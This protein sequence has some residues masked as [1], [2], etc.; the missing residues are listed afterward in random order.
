MRRFVKIQERFYPDAKKLRAVFDR[1]FRDPKETRSDRFVWDYWHVPDQYTF[2]RTPAYH[3]FPKSIYQKFHKFLL[4]WGRRN[5]GCRDLSPPWLSYY[6]DGCY[7]DLHSDVPHGPWAYVFSLSMGKAYRGGETRILRPETLNYW[8]HFQDTQDR[9]LAGIEVRIPSPF[10]RLTVF[11]P[12]F[13]HGVSEVRGTRDPREGRLVIHGWFTEPK[14][15]FE[16][17]LKAHSVENEINEALAALPNIQDYGPMHGTMSLRI[18]V[19]RTGA[20]RNV[21]LFANSVLLLDA[22]EDERAVSS[23][24]TKIVRLFSRL[25]FPKAS[26]ATQITVPLLFR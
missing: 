22:P 17:A 21:S 20:V 25:R 11:D 1:R 26:G 5:L 4:E 18:S 12:R 3:Y 9:E 13:P 16:G 24:G 2:V 8:R 14:P 6:V 15:Y 19:A 23:L 7:Q 10:N